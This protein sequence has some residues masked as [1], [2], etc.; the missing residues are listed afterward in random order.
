ME[1]GGINLFLLQYNEILKQH[2]LPPTI[3]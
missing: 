3:V 2:T 1:S